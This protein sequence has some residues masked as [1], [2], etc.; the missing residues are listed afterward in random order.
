MA[1]RIAESTDQ[2]TTICP[3]AYL[4]SWSLKKRLITVQIQKIFL[5]PK[6][7]SYSAKFTK[8]LCPVVA[9]VRQ[10]FRTLSCLRFGLFQIWILR[11]LMLVLPR[12]LTSLDSPS[13]Q[14]KLQYHFGQVSRYARVDLNYCCQKG[15]K[16]LKGS[17]LQMK[18]QYK[19]PYYDD[20][21]AI[22]MLST[23]P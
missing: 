7:A 18:P 20:F 2:S 9:S 21:C 13:A 15:R 5:P 10:G 11:C 1:R 3:T 14:A 19:K 6:K 22:P 23:Y 4:R 16:L 17:A 12:I 8:L